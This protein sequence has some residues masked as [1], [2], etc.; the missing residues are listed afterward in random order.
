M[1]I[2]YYNWVQFDKKNNDGG[3]VNVYQ[4]NV[5]EYLVK[6]T[7][8]EIYFISSGIYYDILK[9]KTY[10]KET[11]NIFG[12]KCKTYK[13][14][15]SR[16]VAPSK[17]M[18]K[19][20]ETYIEDDSTYEAL[21]QFIK[22]HGKFDIIHFNNIEG[23]SAKC[24]EIK[25]DFPDTKIIYSIHNYF[26]FC[27]QINLYYNNECNCTNFEDGNKCV[28][29]LSNQL[30]KKTFITFYKIDGI[31]EKLHLEN[32]SKKIKLFSKKI[33]NK[34]KR[35]NSNNNNN[36]NLNRKIFVKYREEN[37]KKI[38]ENVDV[39][40]AVSNRVK[41]IAIKM[42]IDENKIYTNYIGTEFAKNSINHLNVEP[43][44]EYF[45][46]AYMGYFDKMKGY[47]FLI[48]A[49][50]NLPEEI[51]K[52]IKFVCY[53]K[54]KEPSDNEKIER[55]QKLENK[56]YSV[57]YHNGYNHK[58]L[59]G[60]LSN[61]NLGIIPVV[62]E[63]N[64]PQVAIEYVAHG[65]PVLSSDLGGAHELSKCDKFIFKSG[66]TQDFIEK[67]TQIIENKQ[68]L[69]EFFNESLK[70]VTMEEHIKQLLEYY[71]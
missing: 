15:N 36:N 39:V 48:N 33:K 54:I 41:E 6:N 13:I 60:I 22:E 19:D 68:L 51:A 46:I 64:L 58:E 28:K 16:C 52:K 70:L 50:E 44:E 47:D 11:K 45:T 67:L 10:I 8:N 34:I 1:K 69:N 66:D 18:Y 43:K 5:I 14:I 12:D 71:K 27:P 20:L 7:S 2:L 35:K 38:N 3:G 9:K 53:A 63:D 32:L 4:K 37:V 57:E 29:C 25:K 26:L 42:G 23:L 65:V 61:I 30:S 55:L 21:K 62:W 24:L 49:L 59:A 17:A 40:L 31:C 56:L